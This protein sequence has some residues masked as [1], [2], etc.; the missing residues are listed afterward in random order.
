MRKCLFYFFS[1]FL[2]SCSK[3][4]IPKID[5]PQT[6]QWMKYIGNYKV[7]DTLGTFLY[8]AEIIHFS[9][10]N[11]FGVEVDSI[12]IQNF[13]DKMNLK[14]EYSFKE[15]DYYFDLRFHDSVSDYYG[16]SWHIS[17]ISDDPITP[18]VENELH[19]DSMV[20][21]FKMTNL[22]YYIYESV[23]YFDCNCK[24]VYKKQ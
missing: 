4:K 9:S 11:E 22:P 1:V 18:I 17:R 7:Y 6:E 3:D 19:D 10:F 23:P 12:V 5:S 16:K 24:H 13:A 20:L 8:D 21:Y 2:I 15:N 14:F